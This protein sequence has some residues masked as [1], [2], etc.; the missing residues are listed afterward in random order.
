[1]KKLLVLLLLNNCILSAQDSITPASNIVIEGIPAI[2]SDIAESVQKYSESRSAVFC[3][4]HPR[5]KEMIISTR[6]GNVPQL[7]LL[8]MPYGVRKQLTF[9]NEPISNALFEPVNG[10]YFLFSKDKGGDEFSHIYRYNLA[11]GK[12]T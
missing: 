8:K 7:H 10:N 3:D 1:M 2:P 4:W 12:I 9:F 11:D 5:R 6:F